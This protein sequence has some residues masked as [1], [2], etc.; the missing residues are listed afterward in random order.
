MVDA[1]LRRGTLTGCRI[2]LVDPD[3]PRIRVI[4]EDLDQETPRHRRMALLT[5]YPEHARFHAD[6]GAA[7][8]GKMQGMTVMTTEAAVIDLARM[9][10]AGYVVADIRRDIF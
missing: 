4:Y 10:R 5:F 7:N 3:A 1:I 6:G 9:L 8:D 2:T